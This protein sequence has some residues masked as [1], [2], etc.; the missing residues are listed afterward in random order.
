MITTK[1]LDASQFSEQVINHIE[2]SQ[3]EAVEGRSLWQDA[4]SRIS[5][6]PRCDDFH[7]SA[8]VYRA[9]H[10]RRATPDPI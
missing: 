6:K 1:K 4:W 5:K 8:R 9:M 2:T 7:L 3:I 10:N